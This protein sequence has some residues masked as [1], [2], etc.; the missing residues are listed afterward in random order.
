M[1]QWNLK[2]R[3][4]YII[5][6]FKILEV[7]IEKSTQIFEEKLDVFFVKNNSSSNEVFK[8][9]EIVFYICYKNES[10]EVLKVVVII[11]EKYQEYQR[12]DERIL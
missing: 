3:K 6:I 4:K 1:G 5:I 11:H 12:K 10:I 9:D 2:K 8:V 7:K